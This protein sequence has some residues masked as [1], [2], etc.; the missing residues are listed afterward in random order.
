MS[1]STGSQFWNVYTYNMHRYVNSAKFLGL[2]R[3][4][5][6]YGELLYAS[7]LMMCLRNERRIFSPCPVIKFPTLIIKRYAILVTTY[8]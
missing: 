7:Q 8:N 2:D 4:G 1:I 5:S 6:G 3:V